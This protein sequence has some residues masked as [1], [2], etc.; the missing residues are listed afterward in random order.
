MCDLDFIDEK[1]YEFQL[2]LATYQRKMTKHY[3]SKVKKSFQIS[4]LV[5][6]IVFLTSKEQG[7]GTLAPNWEIL[8]RIRKEIQSGTYWIKDLEGKVQPRP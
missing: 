7:V 6:R 4:D 1:N 3:N 5:F 8:Y 2:R